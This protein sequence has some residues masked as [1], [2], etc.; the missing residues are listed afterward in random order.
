MGEREQ[1]LAC[2]I[3]GNC[4]D[5]VN[6]VMNLEV[7]QNA[8]NFLP[9][10]VKTVGAWRSLL[11]ASVVLV[12][13]M[14]CPVQPPERQLSAAAVLQARDSVISIHWDL[15]GNHSIELN[16]PQ[17]VF[18]CTS[19]LTVFPWRAH[20]PPAESDCILYLHALKSFGKW[21]HD[22]NSY[23]RFVASFLLQHP[24][25]TAMPLSGF[26]RFY[27][28]LSTAAFISWYISREIDLNCLFHQ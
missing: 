15:N 10:W 20:F 16:M 22:V 4:R 13:V 8:R 21:L 3:F 27:V 18:R 19:V 26:S 11:Q 28:G 6:T 23:R 14:Q 24:E 17:S 12:H 1:D 2:A 25:D 5:F 9:S 7:A